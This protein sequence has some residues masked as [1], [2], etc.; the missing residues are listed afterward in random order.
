MDGDTPKSSSM[1]G[2]FRVLDDSSTMMEAV[3]DSASESNLRSAR[4]SKSILRS[5]RL[6]NS[7][8]LQSIK[9]GSVHD[10]IMDDHF[11]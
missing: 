2:V 7:M 9:S 8:T 1:S 4:L 10:E 3:K 5:Y 6:K 11:K